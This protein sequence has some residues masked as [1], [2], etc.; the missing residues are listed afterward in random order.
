ME[1]IRGF[2]S[3]FNEYFSGDQEIVSTVPLRTH[4]NDL[5]YI[6]PRK[7]TSA[8]DAQSMRKRSEV[9]FRL[10]KYAHAAN[11]FQEQH[12]RQIKP[13]YDALRA[14][15]P[16]FARLSRKDAL[17]Q[18]ADFE[19]RSAAQTHLPVISTALQKLRGLRSLE[20]SEL[21]PRAVL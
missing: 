4:Y 3:A 6:A 10:M 1:R 12:A 17:D 11:Y 15:L 14:P 2:E 5:L 21:I 16:D 9:T 7:S 8:R 20:D 19:A 18:I 13:A